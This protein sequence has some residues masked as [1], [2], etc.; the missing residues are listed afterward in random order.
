M[1]TVEAKRYGWFEYRF[2]PFEIANFLTD[3]RL[4][5]GNVAS[6]SALEGQT[7]EAIYSDNEISQ[8]I[9]FAVH[10]GRNNQTYVTLDYRKSLVEPPTYAYWRRLDDFLTDA[11]LCLPNTF[12]ET[13]AYLLQTIG[14]W[15]SG[16]W[17][18]ELKREFYGGGVVEPYEQVP[19]LPIADPYVISLN[20]SVPTGWRLIDTASP[21]TKANLKFEIIE[22]INIPFLSRTSPV[23]GFQGDVP[24]LEREDGRAYVIFSELEPSSMRGECPITLLYYTYVD[25]DIF[26]TFRSHPSY[27]LEL[28]ST[29]DYGFR[30]FPPRRELWTTKHL[31]ELIPGDEPRPKDNI[32]SRHSQLSY[33]IWLRVR[34]ALADAWRSWGTPRRL[35]KVDERIRLSGDY[36]LGRTGLV[37]NY[38]PDVHRGFVAGFV[39]SWYWLRYK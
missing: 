24:Y 30:E 10:T 27:D 17:D 6:A 8:A 13:N 5:V 16:K 32:F 4:E 28:L 23:E 37:G 3:Q 31:G 29:S 39:N 33:P 7:Y 15:I 26:F 2:D 19:T 20:A 1:T 11:L 12:I 25:E 22:G 35:V 9:S 18:A 21:K 36:E 34:H 14:G 38:G